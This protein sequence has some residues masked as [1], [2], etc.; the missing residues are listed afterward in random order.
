M[1]QAGINL[2]ISIGGPPPVAVATPPLLP[3]PRFDIAQTPRIIFSPALGFYIS[4]GIPYDIVYAG[5]S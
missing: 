5:Q 3:P 4:V 2:D 1:A